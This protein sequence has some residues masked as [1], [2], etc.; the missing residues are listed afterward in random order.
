MKP[1]SADLSHPVDVHEAPSRCCSAGEGQCKAEVIWLDTLKHTHVMEKCLTR[2]FLQAK[3]FSNFPSSCILGPFN[4]QHCRIQEFTCR[5]SR[6]T[7][8]SMSATRRCR[9]CPNPGV[10]YLMLQK[11]ITMAA[12]VFDVSWC[13]LACLV[14]FLWVCE[15]RVG[16]MSLQHFVFLQEQDEVATYTRSATLVFTTMQ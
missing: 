6:A 2:C 7:C 1:G 15:R 13:A 11:L 16:Q 12:M 10:L 5:A 4:L 8:R 14:Y 9:P 3:L